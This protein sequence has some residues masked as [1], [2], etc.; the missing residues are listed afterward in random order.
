MDQVGG[1]WRG[2]MV[3][4]GQLLLEWNVDG[5]EVALGALWM[6]SWWAGREDASK[7]E[8][9]WSENGT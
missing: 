2:M 6:K 1:A 8:D 5:V 7:V 3:W 4:S 9:R